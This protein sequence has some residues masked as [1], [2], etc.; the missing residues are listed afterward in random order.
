[1]APD[2]FGRDHVC[3]DTSALFLSYDTTTVPDVSTTCAASSSPQATTTSR[4]SPPS[5]DHARCAAPTSRS[6]RSP[7]SA[8][9]HGRHVTLTYTG[10]STSTA[11]R[12]DRRRQPFTV[13]RRDGMRW[14][15]THR[16]P[17]TLHRLH[18]V[19]SSLTFARLR[20]PARHDLTYHDGRPYHCAGLV[21]TTIT[22][23][24]APSLRGTRED[25]QPP[26]ASLDSVPCGALPQGRPCTTTAV[27][28]AGFSDRDL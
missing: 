25:A 27:T 16:D 8:R 19:T 18:E 7:P 15:D 22:G 11:R 28:E 1:M 20:R 26:R 13:R 14:A 23:G 2:R 12:V 17:S 3:P 5:L 9:R 6:Q 10:M 24:S 4:W 21:R